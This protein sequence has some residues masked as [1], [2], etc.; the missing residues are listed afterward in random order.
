MTH[1]SVTPLC[2]ITVK[3]ATTIAFT[4]FALCWFV[5]SVKI[6]VHAPHLCGRI[7]APH[8]GL[9]CKQLIFIV[10]FSWFQQFGLYAEFFANEAKVFVALCGSSLGAFFICSPTTS[11]RSKLSLRRINPSK[12][13]R[14]RDETL[15]WNTALIAFSPRTR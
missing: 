7:T 12:E 11:I 5:Y 13:S 1:K 9:A 6:Y 3:T 2:Y 10:I 8:T 14:L 15:E 4:M